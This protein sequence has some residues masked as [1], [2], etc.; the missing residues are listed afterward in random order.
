MVSTQLIQVAVFL[1]AAAIAAPLGR[2]PRCNTA[3]VHAG[4]ES[5]ARSLSADTVG[6]AAGAPIASAD[7]LDF[8]L[9]V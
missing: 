4:D 8:R 3:A 1:A 7:P 6:P 2:T 9:Q 5:A